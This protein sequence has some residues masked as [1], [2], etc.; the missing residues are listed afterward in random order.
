MDGLTQRG[1]GD[2]MRL[3]VKQKYLLYLV[4]PVLIA[5]LLTS[6]LVLFSYRQ[7]VQAMKQNTENNSLRIVENTAGSI[8]TLFHQIRLSATS[9][10]M[11]ITQL[12]AAQ[13]AQSFSQYKATIDQLALLQLNVESMM[14]PVVHY[15]YVFLFEEDRAI[16]QTSNAHQA[17]AL[18]DRY[19]Q[20]NDM[21]YEA[22]RKRFTGAYV[23]GVRTTD[24]RL[25][26]ID[27]LYDTW[28]IAQSIPINPYE[29]PTGVIL[30]TL[31]LSAL[32][33]CLADA[34]TDPEAICLLLDETGA[35]LTEQGSRG[36]WT[37]APIQ[38]VL[39]HAEG[40]APGVHYR[41]LSSGGD[42]LLSVAEGKGFRILTAQPAQNALRG[43]QSFHW[44]MMAQSL[45]VVLVVL[46]ILF[47][48]TRRS[49]TS[50]Q[51]VLES[52]A[53]HHPNENA[54]DLFAYIRDA[55]NAMQRENALLASHADRQMALLHAIFLRRLLRGELSS[56]SD[57]IRE[58]QSLRLSLGSPYYLVLIVRLKQTGEGLE[59]TGP[60]VVRESLK[61]E[62]G[63]NVYPVD[64]GADRI[65][66]LLLV[67]EEDCRGS[68]LS[69][70]AAMRAAIP[71]QTFAS[72]VVSR[73]MD[74]PRAYREARIVA[75]NTREDD[76]AAVAWYDALYRDDIL[77][78]YDYSLYTE[79]KLVNTIATGN[80]LETAA[81]LD[82]LYANNVRPGQ[83]AP[84]V[85]HFFAY[86]LYRLASHA[87]S[88]YGDGVCAAQFLQLQTQLDQVIDGTVPFDDFFAR[89]RQLCLTLCAQNQTQLH[90]NNTNLRSRILAYLGERFTDPSL[91]V[92]SVADAFGISD[93]Y[94]SQF[95]KE[96]T[97]ERLSTYI[98]TLRMERA[99]KLMQR[100]GLNI[101]D[102]AAQS[103][104]VSPHTFR[105]AFKKVHGVTPTQYREA[106]R[107]TG[108]PEAEKSGRHPE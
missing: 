41:T 97:N 73:I 91:N 64:M 53:P 10:S 21:P 75:D 77:Y 35:F 81:T 2:S 76:P 28:M 16:S 65:A 38:E 105:A 85:L 67:Q 62:F 51:D 104:Y 63:E 18:Y 94:L 20:L 56:E 1:A 44:L 9:L 84:R 79:K 43:V 59:E 25:G 29:T 71:A 96:Q 48:Y 40:L 92:T 83:F 101:N 3:R 99:C 32:H 82:A 33:Q 88:T 57:C 52:I 26:Y 78:N 42:M 60:R 98:E 74:V 6:W 89:V 13:A 27:E 58:Q 47:F 87:Y 7:G 70:A 80:A 37:D 24:E 14:N 107:L 4:I 31:D 45:G 34:L 11:Q 90:S 50:V 55:L 93:K 69:A 66:C 15:G 5:F 103:G 61:A 23:S 12:R 86:D 54:R 108:D 100:E 36:Q 8:E 22:F 39:G 68:V 102:I 106:Q 46:I 49:M 19:F 72:T 30:F 17:K 95:F